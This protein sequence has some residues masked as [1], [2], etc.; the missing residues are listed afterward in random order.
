MNATG[1]PTIHIPTIQALRAVLLLAVA[2]GAGAVFGQGHTLWQDGGVQLCGTSS[3]NPV[4][5]TSDSAGGAVVV[6][7]GFPPVPGGIYAQ[8]VDAAGVPQWTA[9][10]VLLCYPTYGGGLQ[11]VDDGKHGAIAVYGT[12]GAL[13]VQRVNAS[14]VPLWGS[15]G[16]ALRDGGPQLVDHASASI[17]S[18]AHGGAIVAW[19][20]FPEVVTDDTLLACRVDSAGNKQWEVAISVDIENEAPSLCSDGLGGVI[21]AWNKYDPYVRH[22]RVQR[23]DSAGV[24]EWGAAGVP[25]CTTTTVQCIRGCVAAGGGGFVVGWTGASDST[26]QNRAQMLGLVGDRLWGLEG[27]PISGEAGAAWG[28]AGFS[29]GSARQSVW[30]WSED[31]AG[32]CDFLPQL[33]DSVGSRRWDTAGIFAGSSDTTYGRLSATDDGKAGAIAAWTLY[34]SRQDW[35]IYAQ[36]V[37]SAGH[38]CWSDTGLAVCGGDNNVQFPVGVTDGDGG[39]IILWDDER[40]LYAQRVADGAGVEETP[41]AEVQAANDGPSVVRGVLFLPGDRGPRTGDRA[42][43]H[44]VVGREVLD[45]KPGANDVRA[46]APGVYFVR[47]EPSAVGCQP[48]AVTKVV[49]TR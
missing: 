18:D 17:V 45:L 19:V 1:L 26:W 16:L 15:Q 49:V 3:D 39:A 22:V 44:D 42:A 11:V 30:V 24:L 13:R 29:A 35:D 41:N 8:R 21:V 33:L 38:L 14:G 9:N 12:L 31:R 37:D 47:S 5:A 7:S 28:G 27:V 2:L 43:L 48:S 40:G 4:L 20:A 6:W 34:R 46:L 23:V 25:V 32:T 10:G 36:H